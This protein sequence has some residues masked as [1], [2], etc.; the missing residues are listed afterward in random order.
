M[1]GCSARRIERG[2]QVNRQLEQPI[3]RGDHSSFSPLVI[4]KYSECKLINDQSPRLVNGAN[5]ALKWRALYGAGSIGTTPCSEETPRR[6][7]CLERCNEGQ[8][9]IGRGAKW[10]LGMKE[11][12]S[13]SRIWA[14]KGA[15][16]TRL[17][18]SR[19]TKESHS[20]PSRGHHI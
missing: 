2:F 7:K 8:L 13:F 16:Q 18:P 6:P 1:C 4:L 12:S 9:P 3:V 20:G 10:A 19:G 5:E 14:S 11:H 17:D 15:R